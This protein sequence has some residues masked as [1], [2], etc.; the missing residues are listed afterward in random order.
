MMQLYTFPEAFGLRNVSPFCL[1]VEMTLT[2]LEM[3]FE[4][5]LQSDPRKSPKGKLPYLVAEGEVIADS[6]L[7]LEYLDK[8]TDGGLYGQLSPSEYAIGMAWTRLAEDH[9]YWIMVAS[10]WLDDNWFA[11]VQRGFFGGLPPVIGPVVAKVARK[12]IRQTYHLQGLGRHN[13]DEQAG[14]ARRDLEALAGAL[15][16]RHYL[17]GDRLTVFDFGV[18]SLLAGLYDNEPATWLTDIAVHY[19]SVQ[20]Y[21]ERIQAEVGVYARKL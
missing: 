3:D 6:E 7:I 12:Q 10:R 18:A 16:G 14:F 9:L 21:A 2:W 20:D 17:V 8:R 19:S 5:V 15:H 11:H 13:L 1:K 4:I